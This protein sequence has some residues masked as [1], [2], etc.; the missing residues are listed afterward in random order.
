VGGR[1]GDAASQHLFLLKILT[2][3]GSRLTLTIP[4]DSMMYFF[5]SRMPSAQPHWA[6]TLHNYTAE[7]CVELSNPEANRVTNRCNI[8]YLR[9]G[10]EVCPTTGTEHLQ[11]YMQL[12]VAT[13]K[14]HVVAW[15]RNI[16]GR[17]ETYVTGCKGSAQDNF[18]YTGKV[19]KH[20][21]DGEDANDVFEWGEMRPISAKQQGKRKDL[22]KVKEAIDNGDTF[23]E[24]CDKYFSTVARYDT[25]IQGRVAA[26]ASDICKEDLKKELATAVLR[27]W[28]EEVVLIVDQPPHAREVHWIWDS[29]GAKGKSFMAKYLTCMK[30]AL[31]LEP[32]KKA[33]LA[34][35]FATHLSSTT[36]AMK[37]IV[38]FDLS[39]TVAPQESSDGS[40]PKSGPLDVIYSLIEGM[41][42]GYM[43][44]TKYKS[45]KIFFKVP[46]I[47]VF[48]NFRPDETKLSADRW[49]LK[50][51]E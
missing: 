14:K 39:R 28:Q 34:Y 35:I 40:G 9:A 47:I 15:F 49:V 10:F 31:I 42:N 50:E 37:P 3:S 18:D 44:S 26:K 24:I 25:F 27:D 29:I 30:D 7:E 4:F 16:L 33:D 5:Y 2:L 17:D 19:G 38:I 22:D 6:W 36:T 23:E 11:G 1:V 43:I 51:L 12:S 13:E 21:V 20:Q 32:G 46:H 48:A 45:Q 41:K 8:T